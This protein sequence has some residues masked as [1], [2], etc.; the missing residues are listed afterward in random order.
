MKKS[1][2]SIF[3]P[4]HDAGGFSRIDG[5]VE[6]FGRVR[7][8]LPPSGNIL[9]LGAG[10][11]Q[12]AQSGSPYLQKLVDLRG[13]GRVIIGLDVDAAVEENPTLDRALTYDGTSM[14]VEDET[15]DVVIS[16]Y[17]FEHIPNPDIFC[18]EIARVLKPGGWLCARTPHLFSALVA[19][20]SLV[21]NKLHAKI[22]GYAQDGRAERDVFPTVYKL[23]TSRTIGSHFP[24]WKNCSYT[25]SPEPAYHFNSA[26]IFKILQIYQY[27]KRPFLGGE[28]LMVF[29]Q[30]PDRS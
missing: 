24:L 2:Q 6:Y 4:E 23:N 14:P 16:D 17:T 20:S 21:P 22:L 28:V 27:I 11:G 26:I 29:L 18:R 19:A 13:G 7:A 1:I 9:D 15:I 10:R 12:I 5:T 3:Y 25:Y 30:K 8:L